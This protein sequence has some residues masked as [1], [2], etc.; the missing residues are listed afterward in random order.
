MNITIPTYSK[1]DLA[2]GS[3]W[4]TV[5]TADQTFVN[6]NWT[7]TFTAAA[8]GDST[9]MTI[10]IDWT[11]GAAPLGT[12]QSQPSKIGFSSYNSGFKFDPAGTKTRIFSLLLEFVD[13]TDITGTASRLNCGLWC[14]EATPAAAVA[15]TAGAYYG[16]E[17]TDPFGTYNYNQLS[18]ESIT[19]ANLVSTGG[20]T[21]PATIKS[22]YMNMI[23][24]PT[25]QII[26][27]QVQPS[28]D[29]GAG[30]TF[31]GLTKTKGT[32]SFQT[33][34]AGS[35]ILFGVWFGTAKTAQAVGTNYEFT[36]RL[37]YAYAELE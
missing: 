35:D 3:A 27:T 4:Q 19:A 31:S 37:R 12:P 6:A 22:I 24:L 20:D 26:F 30:Q 23:I 14:A 10:E 28:N 17:I 2:S 13:V 5:T 21:V 9:D 8:N 11:A 36:Y 25:G 15:T 1:M 33:P 18:L 34:S 32:A 7:G 16:G 29:T